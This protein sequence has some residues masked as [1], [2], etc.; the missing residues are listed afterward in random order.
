MVDLRSLLLYGDDGVDAV[1]Y[2]DNLQTNTSGPITIPIPGDANEDGVVDKL[3][4]KALA[5]HWGKENATWL[6][7]DFDGDRLVGPADASILAANW[8]NSVPESVAD[9]PEPGMLLLLLTLGLAA[10]A[11]RTRR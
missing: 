5:N 1:V 6:E 2:V 10:A 8:G 4:L 9:V 3:D 11:R 7:G